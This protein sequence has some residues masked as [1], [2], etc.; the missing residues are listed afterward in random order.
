MGKGDEFID[1]PNREEI[2]A[3]AIK[4]AKIGLSLFAFSIVMIFTPSIEGIPLLQGI[5][6]IIRLIGC[7]FSSL[8]CSGIAQSNGRETSQYG[9][10]GFIAPPIGLLC[11]FEK[12]R[13]VGGK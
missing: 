2:R 8:A 7:A 11:Y 12:P 1:I 3:L 10:I 9:L 5:Y 6:L 4:R 13:K